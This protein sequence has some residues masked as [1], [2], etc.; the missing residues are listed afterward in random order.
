M[1]FQ[2]FYQLFRKTYLEEHLLVA[3]SGESFLWH[4]LL[5][6]VGLRYASENTQY[7]TECKTRVYV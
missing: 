2:E 5:D 7:G 6:V 1:Y 4:L 3:A